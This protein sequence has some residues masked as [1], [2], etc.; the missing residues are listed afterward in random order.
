MNYK[1]LKYR[2]HKNLLLS[3]AK[4]IIFLFVFA[5]PALHY[6]IL[7]LLLIKNRLY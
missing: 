5:H 7:L 3:K 4:I 2:L 1:L 6:K